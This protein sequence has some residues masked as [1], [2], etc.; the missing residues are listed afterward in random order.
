MCYDQNY[1]FMSRVLCIYALKRHMTVEYEQVG[2]LQDAY[3]P[4]V[5]KHDCL[6]FGYLSNAT[7]VKNY[8]K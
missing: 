1:L 4:L 3:H 6:R 7:G 2:H 5:C 8:R